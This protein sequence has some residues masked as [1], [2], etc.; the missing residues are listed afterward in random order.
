MS[1]LPLDRMEAW[2]WRMVMPALLWGGTVAATVLT[3]AT[4]FRIWQ[5]RRDR[6]SERWRMPLTGWLW[7]GYYGLQLVG[8]LWSLNT[9]AWA[10]SLE[11]KAA[12][13][14][15]PLLAGIPGR[16][17]SAD[18]WW[19]VGWGVLAFLVW[20]VGAASWAW[21]LHGDGSGWRYAGFS[22]DVHPTYLSLHAVVAWLG[23]G[24]YW[25]NA[26][27][28]WP[29]SLLVALSLGLMGSKA[30]ILAAVVVVVGAWWVERSLPTSHGISASN[31]VRWAFLAVL[32]GTTWAASSARFA[33]LQ[34]AAEV[35]RSD[36][37]PVR[38][39]SAGRVAVWSAA[40]TVMKAHPMGVGTGDVTDALMAVYE[41][42]GI[43]Y[44]LDRKLNPHNQ[45]LQAGVAFG[46]LGVV[47][48]SVVFG[49]WCRVAWQRKDSLALLCGALVLAHALVESVLEVQRGV[50]FIVWLA[51]ALFAEHRHGNGVK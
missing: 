22:G 33:E 20:R 29:F 45:W 23:V 12:L 50:V 2:A 28:V 16:P 8:G 41:R 4:L 40:W 11:V 39:S 35:V 10:F 17:L 14:F 49:A 51:M 25:G 5:W 3:L 1:G 30:G 21:M 34:T 48:L 27:L 7:W 32:L 47:W 9:E 42:E 43:T 26:K 31:P 18:F 15:L 19:S 6:P 37:A 13:F 46:W 38:S 44:A 36:E 24:R